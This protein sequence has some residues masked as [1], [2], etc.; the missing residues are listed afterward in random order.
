MW[1]KLL[2][3]REDVQDPPQQIPC[4]L[5]EAALGRPD[6]AAI[7]SADRTISYSKLDRMV[8]STTARLLEAGCRPGTRVALYLP[9]DERYLVLLL[10]LLRA[11]CVACPLSTRLPPEGVSRLLEKAGCSALIS[12]DE[13]LPGKI[14]AEVRDLRPEAVLGVGNGGGAPT[15]LQLGRLATVIFTSGSTGEPKAAIHTVGNH[16]YSAL[17]ANANVSLSLDDR[18]L[19]SLPL[20]HVGG[21]SILF[22][23]LLAG[24][25]IALP[26]PG[27]SLANSIPELGITHVSLVAT[28]LQ[29]LLEEKTETGNLKAALLGGGPTPEPLM[30]EAIRRNIPVHTS[31]GLTEMASQVTTTPPGAAL[32][33]LRTSGRVL[34]HR[35]VA[36][37][38]E[39]EIMV[40]GETL[41]A[42]YI[43]GDAVNRPL[44][45]E[46]WFHTG[47]LSEI[48]AGGN[49][50]VQGRLDN[51]FISGGE[52]I[53]PEEIEAA[54]ERIQGVQRAIVVPVPDNEFGQ[55]PVAFVRIAGEETQRESLA[56]KL[57]KTLPR[58]KVPMAFYGWPEDADAGGMKPDRAFFRSRALALSGV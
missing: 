54:L 14:P 10:A 38:G 20:Y 15:Y 27:V 4:P 57:E 41:F 24:A 13:E 44:D 34:K 52:N 51:L 31:Y 12:D 58:F 56:E 1:S 19:L 32:G 43:E 50:L 7:F 29:R 2:K 23:C 18:W 39:G 35:E 33:D 49:L 55:R 48:D 40:R 53:Q 45:V 21:I 25:T 11:R 6:A 42:G 5:R 22:R 17:G 3:D 47:D 37:S 9:R 26:E 46:G 16:Y 8:S 30:E 36:V 28:Q